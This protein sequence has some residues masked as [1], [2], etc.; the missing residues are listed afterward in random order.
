MGQHVSE[1]S[2]IVRSSGNQI[3]S[4]PESQSKRRNARSAGGGYTEYQPEIIFLDP[5]GEQSV[6]IVS[7]L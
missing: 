2:E 7:L 5:V 6:C 4:N 3:V 1:E